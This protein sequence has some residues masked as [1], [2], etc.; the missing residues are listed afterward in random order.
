M[1]I[2]EIRSRRTAIEI[3]E[4]ELEIRETAAQGPPAIPT[5]KYLEHMADLNNPH[6]VSVAQ[7]TL[8]DG[9]PDGYWVRAW[10]GGLQLV[11]PPLTEMP[12]IPPAIDEHV[13]TDEGDPAAGYLDAK[14]GG[15][16][17]ADLETHKIRLR[18]DTGAAIPPLHYYGRNENGVWGFWPIPASLLP[19]DSGAGPDDD[20]SETTGG[21]FERF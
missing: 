6:R 2:I 21:G 17:A 9:A 13:R 11:P 16:I 19:P 10:D 8:P 7:L 14:V 18:G 5:G 3:S 20:M 15:Q 12:D 1:R 4:E